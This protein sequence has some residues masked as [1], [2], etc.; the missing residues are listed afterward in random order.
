MAPLGKEE[1]ELLDIAEGSLGTAAELKAE[2]DKI[3]TRLAKG[4]HSAAFRG[5]LGAVLG[6]KRKIEKLE[7][8]M[9]DRQRVLET[10]LLLRIWYAPSFCRR[11][12]RIQR[13]HSSCSNK[14]DALL[15]QQRSDFASLDKLL[16]GFIQARAR[17]QAALDQLIHG[18][19]AAVRAHIDDKAKTLKQSFEATISSKSSQVQDKISSRLQDMTL[20]QTNKEEHERLLGSLKHETMNARRNRILDNHDETLS[21]IFHVEHADNV[22]DDQVERR[23]CWILHS[24]DHVLT[25]LFIGFAFLNVRF[26]S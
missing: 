22:T 15:I 6:G 26:A 11:H 5:W 13:T 18:E 25:F 14:N 20:N 17:D 12:N 10:R 23:S 21:W 19:S 9:R 4:K 3:S 2:L 7:K 8:V 1:R 24:R 16:Q